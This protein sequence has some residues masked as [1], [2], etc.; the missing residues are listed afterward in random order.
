[1]NMYAHVGNDPVNFTDPLGLCTGSLISNDNGTCYAGGGPV[2]GAASG[3]W[4]GASKGEPGLKNAKGQ[5]IGP[6][7][8]TS[9]G[10]V[11]VDPDGGDDGGPIVV[12]GTPKS[13]GYY[14]CLN[15]GQLG[16]LNQQGEIV[17][18]SAKY[19]WV[20]G[21]SGNGPPAGFPSSF[22]Y[23][24]CDWQCQIRLEATQCIAQGLG[25][26]G[27][28]L[29]TDAGRASGQIYRYTEYATWAAASVVLFNA[30]TTVARCL[31]GR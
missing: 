11:H 13:D 20:P 4:I 3:S 30:G 26:P 31:T 10:S 23:S 24:Q 29:M 6:G 28:D 25:N 9:S 12:P 18:R 7:G 19:K 16:E 8:R 17:V 15:C 5:P 14:E 2:T 1:M 27:S 21:P 22:N